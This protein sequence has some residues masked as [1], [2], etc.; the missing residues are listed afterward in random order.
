MSLNII[1]IEKKLLNQNIRL[2][3]FNILNLFVNSL[4]RQGKLNI[5]KSI[6]SQVFFFI[7]FRK[8]ISSI[9]FLY[10]A[11]CNVRPLIGLKNK[12]SST[13]A[14]RNAKPQVKPLSSRKS[15]Q[16][17]IRWLIEGAKQRSER[18]MSLRLYYELVDAYDKKGYAIKKKYE[19]HARPLSTQ[20]KI[21]SFKKKTTNP[22]TLLL[23]KRNNNLKN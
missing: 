10:Q 6:L 21:Y 3:A 12:S 9:T 13:G 7:K 22:K 20:L 16:L 18:T 15:Y 14:K 8:Q 17:A 2:D 4:S 5:A 11:V 1:Q 19:W 23:Q